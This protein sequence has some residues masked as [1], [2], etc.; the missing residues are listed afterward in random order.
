LPAQATVESNMIRSFKSSGNPV[1]IAASFDGHLF[2]ALTSQGQVEIY[3]ANGDLKDTVTIDGPADRIAASPSG[4]QLFL[5]DKATGTL[6]IMAVNF[7]Q[8]I[9]TA[10]SP[11]KG[12]EKASVVVTIFSDFQCPYCARISPVLDQLLT[13]YPKDVKVVHKNFPL[14][15]HQFSL[16]AAI[17]ALAAHRQGKFWEMHDKIFENYS[18]LN[19]EKFSE[20]AKA[21]GLNLDKFSKDSNDPQLQQEVQADL[22]NGLKAEVRGTPT[23]FVNGRRVT[24]GGLDGLKALVETELRK[25]K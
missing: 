25:A 11:F 1:D 18:A 16:P 20:F 3:E 13:Q 12:S 24:A 10:G 8:K 21:L 15:S 17:A 23:I 19:D 7:I 14:K 5:S 22:Q 9:D 2:F 6:R 4:D